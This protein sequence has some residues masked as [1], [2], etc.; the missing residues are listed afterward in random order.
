MLTTACEQLL[1]RSNEESVVEWLAQEA[2]GSGFVRSLPS[3][4]DAEYEHDYL[5]GRRVGLEGLANAEPVH[6]RN[7]DL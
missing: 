1:D 7:Q 3:R 5:P 2:V 4:Q 6:A